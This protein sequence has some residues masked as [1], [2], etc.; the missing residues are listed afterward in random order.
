[1]FRAVRSFE[2]S[3]RNPAI[4]AIAARLVDDWR[5]DVVHMHHLTCLSTDIVEMLAA[6]GIP[7]VYTLHDY[8]LLCHRG[9][10]L[11]TAGDVCDGPG[12]SSAS[13]A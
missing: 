7:M 3:Y 13:A 10:R 5:P 9:Q 6:R 11:D 2:E 8:W 12:P 1:M 4:A